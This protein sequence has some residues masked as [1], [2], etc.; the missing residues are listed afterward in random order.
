MHEDLNR[1]KKKPS[2]QS[3]DYKNQPDDEFSIESWTHYLKRNRSIIIDLFCGQY[4]SKVTCPSCSKISITFDPFLSVS[5]PIPHINYINFQ[6][7]FIPR[8][9]TIPPQ[10]VRMVLSSNER[11]TVFLKRFSEITKIKEAFLLIALIKEHKIIE[12]P[13]DNVDIKYLEKHDGITFIFEVANDPLDN[14]GN[15]EKIWHFE[16]CINQKSKKEKYFDNSVSFTRILK[17]NYQVTTEEIHLKIYKHFRNYLNNFYG[18]LPPD[19]KKEYIL[20]LNMKSDSEIKL[21]YESL[22]SEGKKFAPPY[23]LTY[24]IENNQK[25]ILEYSENSFLSIID[26]I[27][28]KELYF[29]LNL[30]FHNAIKIESLKLNKC[31]EANLESHNQNDSKVCS[32]HQCLDQFMKEETLDQNNAWYCGHCKKHQQAHKKIEIY[33]APDLL[34][35]HLKRF[36]SSSGNLYV[37]SGTSKIS[38]F[39][40]FP[41]E[42]LNLN[43]Y[44]LGKK[45][46]NIIY[47]LYAVSNHY[48]GLAG[49]HY[50]A[51]C[52]NYY[53]KKWYEFNDS[54]VGEVLPNRI[55]SEAAYVLFYR[56]RREL[57]EE[58][59]SN[60]YRESRKN[61]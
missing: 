29:E 2:L 17:F 4:K 5:L 36:K 31:Q 34:I 43:N 30:N 51:F 48:G 13:Q 26:N 12:Y 58:I 16:I 22:F 46:D 21:E 55:I 32:L 54:T 8:D 56:R 47:D 23:D 3:L 24:F 45:D 15:D 42:G 19:L 33:K 27:S 38:K 49:G 39:V 1:I 18:N 53:D 7:Y 59:L 20:D 25:K 57:S 14:L 44:I 10:K 50:T 40:D 60:T 35:L 52:Q 61:D 41:I 28:E 11:L 9:S 6:F 37:G